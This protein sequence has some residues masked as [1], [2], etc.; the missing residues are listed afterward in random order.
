M[1]AFANINIRSNNKI[2]SPIFRSILMQMSDGIV[3]GSYPVR[4][5]QRQYIK[6]G[7]GHERECRGAIEV[8]PVKYPSVPYESQCQA[9]DRKDEGTYVQGTPLP[10]RGRRRLGQSFGRSNV[11][12]ETMDD[13][14]VLDVVQSKGGAFVLQLS[15]PNY[16][17]NDRLGAN[18]VRKIS[19]GI[20]CDHKISPNEFNVLF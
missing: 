16:E 19:P 7:D 11:G 10:A 2:S 20:K 1:T 14:I 17:P 6:E 13:V 18:L 3:L 4:G 9:E 15:P 5:Q 12:H 8:S